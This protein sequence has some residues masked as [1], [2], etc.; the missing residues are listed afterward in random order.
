MR[1]HVVTRIPGATVAGLTLIA[2]AWGCVSLKPVILDRKTQL[3]NQILGAFQRLE[4]DLV[5]A[6]SVR[7]APPATK[8]SPLQREAVEAMMIREFY[9]DDIDLLKQEQV[10]GEGNEGLLVLLARPEQPAR[11]AR[12]ERQVKLENDSRTVIMRRVIQTNR[13]MTERDL[14]LVRRIFHRLNAQT[15]GPGERVQREDGQWETVQAPEE[16]P[17][18]TAGKAGGK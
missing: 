6:S 3:E 4:Q 5:L 9:R 14:A 11:A 17:A 2:A 16:K 13:D 18:Q 15:A 7:G 8:L 10:V 1:H 12:V